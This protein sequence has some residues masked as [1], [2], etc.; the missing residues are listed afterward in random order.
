MELDRLPTGEI[1]GDVE[2]ALE[3][4]DVPAYAIDVHGIVRWQNPAARRLVGDVLGRRFTSVVVP[5]RQ[6]EARE[7]FTRNIV[8]ARG[9]KD[10]K[11]ELLGRDGRRVNVEIC[12]APLRDE[13]RVVGMFGLATRTEEPTPPRIKP[14]LTT[15]Q[16]QVVHLLAR[17]YST[18]QIAEHLHVAITTVRTHIRQLLRA[19][20]AHSRI[21]AIA[22]ARRDGLLS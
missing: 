20:G 9:V 2:G 16:H 10:A 6:L 21:E 14:H 15:R 3:E 1:V 4:V 17:G 8:G 7:T 22:V 5:E 18:E 19:L 11:F 13:G 12:S